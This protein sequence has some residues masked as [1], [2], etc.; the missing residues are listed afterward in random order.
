MIWEII[1]YWYVEH[2]RFL[3]WMFNFIFVNPNSHWNLHLQIINK[4]VWLLVTITMRFSPETE[5][6]FQI[7][8]NR[9]K[10]N[11]EL[12]F[13]I[14][15]YIENWSKALCLTHSVYYCNV[16][17]IWLV[18][19][20]LWKYL[21]VIYKLICHSWFSSHIRTVFEIFCKFSN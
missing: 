11:S 18:T 14:N 3:F 12:N 4:Y 13:K 9:T 16:W 1:D 2:F 5:I 21:N 7:S 15:I 19:F 10:I 6:A 8:I 20:E 17:Q